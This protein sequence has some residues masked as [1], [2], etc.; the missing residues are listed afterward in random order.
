MPDKQSMGEKKCWDGNLDVTALPQNS[1]IPFFFQQVFIE[2]LLCAKYT[3]EK[4][5]QVLY[6]HLEKEKE[7]RNKKQT[8][9]TW[10]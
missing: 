1:N 10:L 6:F 2:H 8:L 4:N 5:G 7:T 3:D 9:K